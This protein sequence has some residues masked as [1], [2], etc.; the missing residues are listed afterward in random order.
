MVGALRNQ[1]K[2]IYKLPRE[3]KINCKT[4][5]KLYNKDDEQRTLKKE[6]NLWN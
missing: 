3:E 1:G 6:N 5:F 2:N 4:D